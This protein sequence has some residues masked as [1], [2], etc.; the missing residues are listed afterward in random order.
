MGF[1]PFRS[2][3]SRT[4]D[5]IVVG[6]AFLVILVLVLWALFGG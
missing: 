6:V 4:T 5:A 1:N 3:V 2:R